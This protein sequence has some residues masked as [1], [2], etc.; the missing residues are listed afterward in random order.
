MYRTGNLSVDVGNVGAK[1]PGAQTAPA[2][3]EGPGGSPL[4]LPD[5][6]RPVESPEGK[7]RYLKYGPN[8]VGSTVQHCHSLLAAPAAIQPRRTPLH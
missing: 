4:S 3:G 5:V 8:D 1:R 2:G 7:T 6:P